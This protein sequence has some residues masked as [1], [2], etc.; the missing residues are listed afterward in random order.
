MPY[1]RKPY[2]VFASLISLTQLLPAPLVW[3]PGEG[4]SYES[5]NTKQGGTV[6]N[7]SRSQFEYASS[8][9][10][11]GNYKEARAAY[12]A[13]VRRWPFSFFADDAQ[14]KIGWCLEKLGDFDR[15]FN[16]YQIVVDKYAGTEFFDQ[17]IERQF[18]IANTY[19]A[20]EPQ[21]V[22]RVPLPPSYERTIKKY[23][24]IINNA[25]HGRFAPLAQLR[26]GMCYQAIGRWS[27]AVD[28]FQK[29]IDRYYQSEEVD[30]AYYQIGA[31][32]FAASRETGYDAGA[33]EKAVDAFRDFLKLFP[34]SELAPQARENLA[35][36]NAQ[37]SGGTLGI[38][39]FYENQKKWDAAAIY[40]NEILKKYPNSEDAQTARERLA[41]IQNFLN[42]T[43]KESLADSFR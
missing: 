40:Y 5:G 29:V 34:K 11:K 24:Q 19:F 8:I 32:W 4:F 6:A 10:A 21:R 35:A 13:L 38:A 41:A 42:P 23:Q 14:Y 9:E 33:A 17:A 37:Q 43:T 15:A 20:G 3:R 39:R 1:S 28:A 2:V 31:T 36:I 7:D 22:M 25:P 30:D 18:A 16:A 27:L 26:I 12:A